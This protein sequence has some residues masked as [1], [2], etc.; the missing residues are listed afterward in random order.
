MGGAVHREVYKGKFLLLISDVVDK[1]CIR[2][3]NCFVKHRMD[4]EEMEAVRAKNLVTDYG[5]AEL[6]EGEKQLFSS[7]DPHAFSQQI[8]FAW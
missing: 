1:L 6:T 4:V 2:L 5:S 8:L 7:W 3:A